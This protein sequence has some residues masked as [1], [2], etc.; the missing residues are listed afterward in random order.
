MQTNEYHKNVEVNAGTISLEQLPF[1][2]KPSFLAGRTNSAL[3][4]HA[5]H[6]QP[7]QKKAEP[8]QVAQ[9]FA[10]EANWL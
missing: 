1:G 8:T 5:A 4:L 2:C 6:C 9:V 7:A 3:T 10:A